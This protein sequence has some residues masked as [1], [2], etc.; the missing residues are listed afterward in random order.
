MYNSFSL[1]GK[2]AWITGAA[3]GIGFAIAKAFV[4]AGA[5][6]IIFN[7]S[8]QESMEKGLEAYKEAGIANVHGY[9]CDV[10]DEAA[11][12]ALVEKIHAE[13]GQMTSWSTMPASS[14]AFRCTR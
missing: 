8:N 2:N 3:Y 11:V 9:G 7:P 10:T 6:N 1:E 13:V 12:K 4:E 5:K 14:N